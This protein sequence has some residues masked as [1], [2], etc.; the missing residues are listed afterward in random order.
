MPLI[1]PVE[2]VAPSPTDGLAQLAEKVISAYGLVVHESVNLATPFGL[3]IVMTALLARSGAKPSAGEASRIVV[4]SDP[5]TP[6]QV[7][8]FSES[9]RPLTKSEEAEQIYQS[10]PLSRWSY[11]R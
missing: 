1:A 3:Q 9:P 7:L 5:S 10:S 6:D 2:P 4:S 11:R 8:Q